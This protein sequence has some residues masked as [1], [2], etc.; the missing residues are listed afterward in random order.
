MEYRVSRGEYRS[1]SLT[2]GGVS[3]L[4]PPHQLAAVLSKGLTNSGVFKW[5][6]SSVL[7]S[8]A[9]RARRDGKC[10]DT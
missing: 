3:K 9:T 4:E 10:C 1:A 6:S 7:A 5:V 2:R 8:V